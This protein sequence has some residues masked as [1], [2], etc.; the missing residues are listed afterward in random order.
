MSLT[1]MKKN[2]RRRIFAR[3]PVFW[4][5]AGIL[6]SINCIARADAPLPSVSANT[7]TNANI[8]WHSIP[9]HGRTNPP[10][11]HFYNKINP[12]W[13]F[14]NVDDPIPPDWYRPGEKNRNFLW[15]FRNPLTNFSNYVIGVG[16]KDTVRSGFYPDRTSNPHGGW[17]FAVTRRR[18]VF[19]PFVDYKRGSFEFYF[20]WRLHGNFGVKLNFNQAPRHGPGKLSD[21]DIAPEPPQKYT[22][23]LKPDF[24]GNH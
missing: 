20:G 10:P 7:K 5:V 23:V 17:S 12:V 11:I 14:G 18:I 8:G 13:W 6:L 24:R 22:T 4:L 2:F 15:Y 3:P 1:Y 19:L 16:D 9:M 21:A